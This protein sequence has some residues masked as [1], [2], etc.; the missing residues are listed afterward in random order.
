MMLLIFFLNYTDMSDHF[1]V[2]QYL[3]DLNPQQIITLGGALGLYYPNL[4]KM[5]HPL[6]DMVEAWLKEDD[7]VLLKSGHP[8]WK[9]L[10]KA[11][12]LAKNTGIAEKI[13]EEKLIK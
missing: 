12:E 11:L 13:R 2:T 8:S 5:K 4:K 1:I 6:E 9:S 7:Q 10:V 3:S